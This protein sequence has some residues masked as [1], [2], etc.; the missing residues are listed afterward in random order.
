MLAYG[1]LRR[2]V[3]AFAFLLAL[4][5]AARAGQSALPGAFADIGLSAR[6]MGMGGAAAAGF[7]RA[8][9]LSGN[10][11]GLGGLV[12]PELSAL[13]T[14][15]FGLVPTYYLAAARRLGGAGFGLGLLSSGDALLRENTLLIAGG[16]PLGDGRFGALALGLALKLRHAAFGP[17][18]DLPGIEGSAYGGAIDLGLQ[19]RRGSARYGLFVEELASDLRWQSSGLGAY[20][21]GVPPTLR[22]GLGVD[23]GALSLAADLEVALEAERAHKAALGVEWRPHAVLALRGG[24]SQRLATQEQRFLSAGLGLGAGL[25]G[26]RRFQFDAAYLFHELGGSLR[27]EAALLL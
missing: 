27:L 3:A 21:E 1:T 20:H 15:Q 23:A 14:E 12:R 6:A 4:A 17:E 22:A 25:E 8:A 10:P 18:G 26:G 16:R 7:G 2:G 13:Q 9:D 19:L 11:A 24:L 5:P